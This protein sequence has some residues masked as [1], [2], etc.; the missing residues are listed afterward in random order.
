M[1]DQVDWSTRLCEAPPLCC[2]VSISKIWNEPVHDVT[3]LMSFAGILSRHFLFL[4]HDFSTGTSES[5][6]HLYMCHSAVGRFFPNMVQ[7]SYL[8]DQSP[9]LRELYHYWKFPIHVRNLVHE[10][11]MFH[12]C[13]MEKP[14]LQKYCE[15][16]YNFFRNYMG[17]FCGPEQL[18][19]INPC[20]RFPDNQNVKFY[21]CQFFT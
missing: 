2:A 14:L 13:R 4:I 18:V 1:L 20:R 11:W 19:L 5:S 6:V 15:T 7:L 17:K 10:S 8:R 21:S 16:R 9:A 12:N 3:T